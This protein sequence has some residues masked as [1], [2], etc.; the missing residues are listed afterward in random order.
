MKAIVF[1]GGIG[2]RLWPLSRRHSPKQFEAVVGD[3]SSLQLSVEKLTPEFDW[4]DI[5]LST[6]NKY[7]STVARQL[8][9]L[10]R[11]NI[12]TE[13]ETRD[14]GPAV[15]LMTAILFKKFPKEPIVILWSDHLIKNVINFKKILLVSE[16][17]IS[18]NPHK[19]I[20]ISQKP[21]FASQNLGWIKYGKVSINRKEINLHQFDSFHY[22]PQ[23]PEAENYFHS[24]K[25]AWNTGYFVTTPDFLWTLYKQFQPEIYKTMVLI[26][27]TKSSSEFDRI[28]KKNY[29]L[30]P[31]ISFDNAILEKISV[32]DAFVI[33]AEL[34]WSDIGAW[35][36][37]KEALQTST[38]NNVVKGKVVVTDCQDSLV[39]NYTS[40]LV[41]TIDLQGYLV[42]N[43]PD[44][45]LVC[46][47]N[48]VPKIKK[49][50]ESLSESEN[51]HL[52]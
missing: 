25:F 14:V 17:I 23:L 41:V 5:Y 16:E 20:F 9:L 33:P 10:P 26:K 46:H 13:P 8:P 48:S 42:I 52:V 22:R 28:L 7:L 39:Y 50:V 36:A 27:K 40:Q 21:R 12:I 44:V 3:K 37:L 4:S 35:E 19:I 6:N 29:Y 15:G 18:R 51:R 11:D 24:G 2:T 43:T 38:D 30:L 32:R 47:K 1:A 49:L 34:G 45:V 31:K